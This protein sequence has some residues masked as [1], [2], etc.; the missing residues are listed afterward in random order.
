MKHDLLSQYD[1]EDDLHLHA[2]TEDIADIK[3]AR[4]ERS[5]AISFVKKEQ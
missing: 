1:L 4:L 3:I 2:K 5:G